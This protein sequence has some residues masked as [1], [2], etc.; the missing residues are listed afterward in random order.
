MAREE[1]VVIAV[2]AK[3]AVLRTRQKTSCE[4]CAERDSCQSREHIREMEVEAANPVNARVGDVVVVS[5]P[6]SRLF[7][8][9]FFLY[10][11]PVLMMLAGAILGERLAATRGGGSGLS[12]L[13][14][15]GL[16]LVAIAV[17]KWRDHAARKTGKFRPEIVR[18][19]KSN[20]S[21]APTGLP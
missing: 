11:F 6:T 20:R 17:V 3:T 13:M 12:A 8:L 14:G 7:R 15:F 16:F 10:V 2:H 19:K 1:A 21:A 18:V 9:A 5:F 4:H